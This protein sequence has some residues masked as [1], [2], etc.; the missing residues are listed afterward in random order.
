MSLK[1]GWRARERL[2]AKAMRYHEGRGSNTAIKNVCAMIAFGLLCDQELTPD[3]TTALA[4]LML[5]NLPE[6]GGWA[7]KMTREFSDADLELYH[8]LWA[9]A[10]F[11][12]INSVFE[13]C[14]DWEKEDQN[15]MVYMIIETLAERY[16]L[17]RA[18]RAMRK[19][20]WN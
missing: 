15:A 16:G 19:C 13:K 14:A 8:E 6:K 9:G 4:F 3:P 18:T 1:P 5:P 12:I 2:I 7:C 17:L 20:D 11:D 10:L